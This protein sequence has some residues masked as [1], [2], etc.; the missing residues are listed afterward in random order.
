[1]RSKGRCAPRQPCSRLLSMRKMRRRWH[2]M[3]IMAF[4]RLLAAQRVFIYLSRLRC[5]SSKARTVGYFSK[6][7]C[8][9]LAPGAAI[10]LQ[11]RAASA[12]R[13]LDA[14]RG[15]D[16][17]LLGGVAMAAGDQRIGDAVF[18]ER[19]ADRERAL[20]ARHRTTRRDQV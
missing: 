10:I 12:A 2:S 4:A 8:A 17:G 7:I 20:G 16:L 5:N 3:S 15:A 13:H 9:R 6:L 18:L 11:D 1:M 19:L 14:E